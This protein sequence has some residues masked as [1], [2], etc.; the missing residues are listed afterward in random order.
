[1]PS[2]QE[3]ENTL[4]HDNSVRFIKSQRKGQPKNS[5]QPN[6]GKNP[7]NKKNLCGVS[8]KKGKGNPGTPKR[9][10][11]VGKGGKKSKF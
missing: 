5:G 8:G 7:K 1:M 11:R 6:T 2:E 4:P 10:N 9:S 3:V